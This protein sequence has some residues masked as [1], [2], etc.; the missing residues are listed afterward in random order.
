[1]IEYVPNLGQGKYVVMKLT[2]T[3]EKN[4]N[5]IIYANLFTSVPFAEKLNADRMLYT[6]TVKQ[7]SERSLNE[8]MRLIRLPCVR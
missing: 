3:L 2:S 6:G 4:A 7:K 5:Y 1:M 8:R